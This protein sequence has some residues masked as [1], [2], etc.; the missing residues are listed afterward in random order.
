[1]RGDYLGFG[2][3]AASLMKETRFR[4]AAD[5]AGYEA[6]IAVREAC[7]AGVMRRTGSGA[8]GGRQQGQS[9]AA[10]PYAEWETLSMKDSMAETM[11]LGLRMTRGVSEQAF[12]GQFGS[13]IQEIYGNVLQ[14]HLQNGLLAH[15]NGFYF[16][17]E[18]GLDVSNYV[19]ADFLL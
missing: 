19:M 6:D 13:T 5:M 3:G 17:T 1:M 11:F 14:K 10:F 9:C 4:N 16:L 7:A 8:E 12:S 18:R 15:E 2:L